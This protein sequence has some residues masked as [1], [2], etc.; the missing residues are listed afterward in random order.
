MKKG[1]MVLFLT[2][3]MLMTSCGSGETFTDVSEADKTS[4]IVEAKQKVA[5]FKI[6]KGMLSSNEMSRSSVI[7]GNESKVSYG[8]TKGIYRDD[9]GYVEYQTGVSN[10]KGALVEYDFPCSDGLYGYLDISAKDE[11][12]DASMKVYDLIT[13]GQPRAMTDEEWQTMGHTLMTNSITSK[14]LNNEPSWNISIGKSDVGNYKFGFS[15]STDEYVFLGAPT[16][17]VK[18]DFIVNSDGGIKSFNEN[19]AG[20]NENASY[21]ESEA[22][23]YDYNFSGNKITKEDYRPRSELTEKEEE[24]LQ[25]L[26]AA[27]G[28]H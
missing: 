7:N 26:F 2:S 15:Y 18:G 16:C 9:E 3:A 24:T 28:V 27:I 23:T 1:F 12:V 6:G 11:T 21:N 17:E 4:V 13:K 14:V 25:L 8:Q 5:D 19:I 10:S 22:T 20:S